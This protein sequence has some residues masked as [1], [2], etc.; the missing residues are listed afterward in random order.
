MLLLKYLYVYDFCM[1][2]VDEGKSCRSSYKGRPL[3]K[4]CGC[5]VGCLKFGNFFG[6]VYVGVGLLYYMGKTFQ[7]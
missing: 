4:L 2:C 5:H 7:G 1:H 6:D 3:S